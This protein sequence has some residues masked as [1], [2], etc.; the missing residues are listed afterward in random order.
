MSDTE[1]TGI[2]VTGLHL[3]TEDAVESGAPVFFPA[4]AVD[5]LMKTG[6]W[7]RGKLH[8]LKVSPPPEAWPARWRV[9]AEPPDSA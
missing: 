7:G 2:Y 9:L 6:S 3:I 5:T 4:E 8:R 1:I